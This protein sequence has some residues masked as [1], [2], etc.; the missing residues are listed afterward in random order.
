[1]VRI[2]RGAMTAEVDGDFVVFLIGMRMNKLWKVWKWG[3]VFVSM[4]P[5]LDELANNPELGLLHSRTHLGI[6][7]TLLVQYWR[8]IDQLQT[9]ASSQ[10]NAHLPAWEKFNRTVRDNDAV[11]IWHETYL[12]RAGEYETVYVN[13]PSFGL[14]CAGQILSAAGRRRTARGRLKRDAIAHPSASAT[15]PPAE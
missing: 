8:S 1:M 7:Q 15:L 4:Q 13:M 12:V 14:G 9:Y 2:M 6:R 10:T 5:L 3:P 11:G